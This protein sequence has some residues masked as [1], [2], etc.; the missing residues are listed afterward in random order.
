MRYPGASVPEAPSTTV[1]D[2]LP[3]GYSISKWIAEQWTYQASLLG[4][5]TRT[6]IVGYISG[7]TET[8]SWNKTDMIPR[9]LEASVEQKIIPE[10]FGDFTWIPVNV[11]A[12]VISGVSLYGNPGIFHVVNPETL[13]WK[14]LVNNIRYESRE[15]SQVENI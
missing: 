11:C 15:F 2:A 1:Q 7:S 9:V 10:E 8:G 14:V 12:Q 6:F 13:P 4:L 5:T 3:I